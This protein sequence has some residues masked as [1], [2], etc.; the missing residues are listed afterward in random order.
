MVTIEEFGRRLRAKQLTSERA[1]EDCLRRIEAE[2]PRLNAFILVTAD[3]ALRQAREADRELAAG[4]D[5]GPLHGVP[6]SIKDL[7]DIRGLPTTAASR[8]RDGHVALRDA[9]TIA[10]LRQA[11]VVFVGKTNL[12]E[13]AFGTTSEDSAFGP[14]RNPHDSTRSPGGSS[15]GSGASIASGMAM[16]SVGTDTGGSIRIPAAA[17]GI[18]GLKPSLGE[19]ATDGVVPLSRTLDHVGPLALTVT[20]AA[21]L[22]HALL[23]HVKAV[24]PAPTPVSGLRLAVPRAYFCDLLDDE[25]RARFE[26]ALERLREGGA[27]IDEIEIHHA[28]DIGPVYLHLVLSDAA[29]YH[30]AT[31]ES[32][33]EKYTP[34]VRLR[35]EMARYVLGEDYV[36]ALAGREVLRREVDAALAEHDAVVL[37]TLPIPAPLVGASDVEIGGRPQPIRNVMLRLTQLFNVTG[38]PALS[39]PS[40]R[41]ATGLPCSIQLVGRRMQT[42]AL[43]QV[44]LAC[45]G[46]IGAVPPPSGSVGV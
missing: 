7:L 6:I 12:H 14:A 45:E 43:L 4:Q 25:V 13:F 44:A 33:P 17:C 34:P 3:E 40:G 23:G 30:A 28:R 19:V 46:Q 20:D 5:R 16:A 35:L 39:L 1:T 31:L 18:V 10:H 8:V 27:R 2:N 26:A 24:A 15:G 36:R 37:P 38:H 29:A 22:H 42:D 9:T 21:L 32:M 41:T 11:G